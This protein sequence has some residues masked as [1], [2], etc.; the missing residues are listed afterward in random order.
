MERGGNFRFFVVH[1]FLVLALIGCAGGD[2]SSPSAPPSGSLDSTFGEDG[3]VATAVTS[4]S[5][6]DFGYA[7]AIQPD[8]KILVVGVTDWGT[9][10]YFAVAR[11]TMDG[12]LDPAF[13]GTGTGKVVTGFG[14]GRDSAY[15]VAVQADG[16]ILVGGSSHN[17]TNHD[18]GIARYL[19]DGAL[20]PA[21]NLNGKVTTAVGPG[22]DIIYGLAVQ[23]DGKI[24][25]AGVAWNGTDYDFALAR[26]HSDGRLDSTFG[27]GGKVVTDIG[28]APDHA[29]S[30]ALQSDGKIVVGGCS[31]TGLDMDFTLGRYQA[32]GRLDSS[33]GTGGVVKTPVAVG[34]TDSISGI[35]IQP[36]GKIVA[37]GDVRLGSQWDIA[38]A[39]YRADGSLDPTFGAGGKAVTE[40]GTDFDHAAAVGLQSDGKI[41]LSGYVGST[42]TRTN[43]AVVRYHADGSLDRG[44]GTSGKS[45]TEFS[46]PYPS[47]AYGVGIQPGGKIVA[48]GY[49]YNGSND[50]FALARYNP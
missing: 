46:A 40:L 28:M 21:F 36:D 6:Y 30:V 42:L 49:M 5:S 47:Y 14:H 43:F 45:T 22:D 20:D 8:G 12:S 2:G 33:F 4:S 37:V 50:D 9:G 27:T 44:F 32:D 11:Y 19:A 7:M 3:K 13:G 41:V 31:Q 15:C 16:K 1:G 25:A 24:V 34:G 26:Y 38:L 48:A 23:P 29:K 35:A 17:G 10:E 18:F 39:R